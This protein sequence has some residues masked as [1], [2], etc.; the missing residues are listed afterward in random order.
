MNAILHMEAVQSGSNNI[1][2]AITVAAMRFPH[3]HSPPMVQDST[4]NSKTLLM[5]STP[6]AILYIIAD[7]RSFLSLRRS[8]RLSQHGDRLMFVCMKYFKAVK[9]LI[10]PSLF[11]FSD[12]NIR[13]VY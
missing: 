12:P 1:L 13:F 6:C 8:S 2:L 4:R 11:R 10:K 3:F 9:F 5:S 7:A